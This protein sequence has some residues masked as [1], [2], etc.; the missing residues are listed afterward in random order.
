KE[1]SAG[2]PQLLLM[3]AT[4]IPRTL[5]MT[6]FG[7]LDI[8]TIDEL[9]KGRK[10]IKTFWVGENKRAEIYALLDRLLQ[11]GRQGYVICPLIKEEKL[12]SAKSVLDAY[13]ELST[14]F[15]HRKVGILHGRM[16]A[17]DKKKVM[18]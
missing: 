11:E 14:I 10:P 18:Q 16:N 7:D 2:S 6:L 12:F 9:P 8:S 1:K 15:A 17:A 3:T 4:P 13:G 5:A